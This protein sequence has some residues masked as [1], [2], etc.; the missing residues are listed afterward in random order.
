M[1]ITLATTQRPIPKPPANSAT[2]RVRVVNAH[3]DDALAFVQT[4][5]DTGEVRV[6]WQG[7]RTGTGSTRFR[8]DVHGLLKDP[9]DCPHADLAEAAIEWHRL[10]ATTPPALPTESRPNSRANHGEDPR[11]RTNPTHDRK[12]SVS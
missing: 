8:C 3:V 7:P 1:T 11:P 6:R 10:N 12:E 9:E 2:Y 5:Q 4:P